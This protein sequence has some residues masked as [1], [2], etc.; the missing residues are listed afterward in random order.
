MFPLRLFLEILAQSSNRQT[1]LVPLDYRGLSVGPENK[2]A[3]R[4]DVVERRLAVGTK[5]RPA[6]VLGERRLV[7]SRACGVSSRELTHSPSYRIGDRCRLLR[8]KIVMRVSQVDFTLLWSASHSYDVEHPHK[9]P[10]A[11]KVTNEKFIFHPI[12][13]SPTGV[14]Y[15]NYSGYQQI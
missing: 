4:S 13:K 14:N 7:F 5:D 8:I 10:Q 15:S 9:Q 12:V 3:L 2:Y 11:P 6:V 1:G